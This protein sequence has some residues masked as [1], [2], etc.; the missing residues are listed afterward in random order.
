MKLFKRIQSLFEDNVTATEVNAALLE[1]AER[2]H[3]LA[4]EREQQVDEQAKT[5]RHMNQ[6]NH[7]SESL[8]LAFRGRTT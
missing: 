2:A 7:Y 6:K 3:L 4:L 8:T 1:D 5:L